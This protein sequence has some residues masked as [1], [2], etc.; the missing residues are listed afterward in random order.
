M[1]LD[2][3]VS[4]FLDCLLCLN[5]S[6]L[7]SDIPVFQVLSSFYCPEKELYMAGTINQ[8]HSPDR[9]LSN[10]DESSNECLKAT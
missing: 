3:C 9:L 2:T 4:N 8:V 7:S 6:H 10:D 1:E 5:V